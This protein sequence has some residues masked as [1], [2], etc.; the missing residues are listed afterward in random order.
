MLLYLI[1]FTP[2][3]HSKEVKKEYREQI[4]KIMKDTGVNPNHYDAG[5]VITINR[6]ESCDEASYHVLLAKKE[7][8]TEEHFQAPEEI[9]AVFFRTKHFAPNI[10]EFW[11]NNSV[12]QYFEEHRTKTLLYVKKA[13]S[14]GIKYFLSGQPD[15]T[16]NEFLK[17]KDSCYQN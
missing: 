6:F 17:V 4:Y 13:L 12:V 11:I 7:S 2:I 9:P 14:E 10:A 3:I 5:D 1:L 15:N 8:Y 16:V